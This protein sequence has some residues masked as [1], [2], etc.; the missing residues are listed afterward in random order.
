[1]N[2]EI[3]FE[4]CGDER[5]TP[6]EFFDKCHAEFNFDIDVAAS[7]L[8]HKLPLY[9]GEGGVADDALSADWAGMSCWMNPPYSVAG[10]FVAKAKEEADKGAF[11]AVL[12]AARSDTKYWHKYI[13]DK[14][15]P[16]LH[17]VPTMNTDGNWYPGVRGRFIPG[18]LAFELRVPLKMRQLVIAEMAVADGADDGGELQKIILNQLV[19]ATGLPRMAIKRICQGMPDEDLLDAAPFPSALILFGDQ[20]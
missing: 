5:V 17:G 7:S 19:E 13:W 3:F 10:A 1:M 8:N 15:A 14:D 12:I 20:K 9:F 16:M 18:R 11:V 6:Q 2:S 4:S